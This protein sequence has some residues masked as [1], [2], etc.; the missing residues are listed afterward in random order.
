MAD[1]KANVTNL[2]K[3]GNY[4]ANGYRPAFKINRNYIST[5]VIELIDGDI[6]KVGESS[7]AYISFLTPEIYPN[8]MWKGK[9]MFFMEGTRITGQAEIGRAHV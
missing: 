8:S 3:S 9:K 6:L 1:I 2:R 5:G 4:F 7:E